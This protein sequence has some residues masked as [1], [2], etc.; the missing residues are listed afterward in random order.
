[1]LHNYCYLKN[2]IL[3][4]F[5]CLILVSYT[6]DIFAESQ[7]IPRDVYG[8]L[9]KAKA[10]IELLRRQSGIRTSW[11]KISSNSK[12]YPRHSLQKCFELLEKIN[13]L[14]NIKQMGII[15]TPRYP[16]RK[17]T[18]DEV[19]VV[20]IRL[21]E[22]LRI[23]TGNANLE[24]KSFAVDPKIVIEYETNYILLSEIS[25][26]LDPVLGIEGFTS[27]DVYAQTKRVI[28]NARF[29]RSSQ[30]LAEIKK[31]PDLN[32]TILRHPNHVLKEVY[33][34]LEKISQIERNLKIDP[35]EVPKLQYRRIESN[36]VYDAMHNVLTELQRIKLC[37]GFEFHTSYPEP[38]GGKA[39]NDVI[40]NLKL[41]QNLLPLF[42]G[43]TPLLRKDPNNLK[44][45]STDIFTVASR[46]AQKLKLDIKA[47]G[48]YIK[49]TKE[50]C[51]G[52][53]ELKH[54]YRKTIE[55]LQ[56]V[57]KL[58]VKAGL[59]ET[60]IDEYPLHE[61]NSCDTFELVLRLENDLDII[62]KVQ[63]GKVYA[64]KA[65]LSDSFD[66]KASAEAYLR[67]CQNSDILGL[68]TGF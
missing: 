35:C 24:N 21:L 60:A 5:L 36:E 16:S 6:A 39:P 68:L 48:F 20:A 18:P 55:C 29:L 12:H 57:N 15:T 66:E 46:I 52:E 28:E 34:V 3:F 26:A 10:E 47:R 23:V 14:R 61:I 56:K 43:K 32:M 53:H 50:Q 9:L 54:I 30:N 4:L 63:Y 67:M 22:E 59:S 17:I 11:P 31:E 58:R 25:R 13:R 51:Q 64:A 38:E 44:K 65:E 45:T 42:D 49:H 7:K 33:N 37:L 8:I 40:Y 27:D 2:R 1:M 19:Y 62:H 41:A